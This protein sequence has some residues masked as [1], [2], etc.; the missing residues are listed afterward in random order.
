MAV[1]P[2]AAWV[3]WDLVA[4]TLVAEVVAAARREVAA[5]QAHFGLGTYKM[6]RDSWQAGKSEAQAAALADLNAAGRALEALA[7]TCC[8][9]AATVEARWTD[10]LQCAARE[11]AKL[12][13]NLDDN[14]ARCSGLVLAKLV[15]SRP[16]ATAARLGLHA[17]VATRIGLLMQDRLGEAAAAVGNLEV[18]QLFA[19]AHAVERGHPTASADQIHLHLMSGWWYFALKGLR[20]FQ[21]SLHSI[22]RAAARHLQLDG[23]RWCMRMAATL[24]DDPATM[25]TPY[26][27]ITTHLEEIAEI[28]ASSDGSSLLLREVHQ[29]LLNV[30]RAWSSAH[31][32]AAPAR[33]W[34]EQCLR[35]AITC[36]RVKCA[37]FLLNEPGVKFSEHTLQHL[38]P[39]A[40]RH[41]DA[42]LVRELFAKIAASTTTSPPANVGVSAPTVATVRPAYGD[43]ELVS[44]A[45]DGDHIQLLQF[46]LEDARFH[47][48]YRDRLCYWLFVAAQKA[49]VR[50][51]HVLFA[52]MAV[53]LGHAPLNT[54]A[55]VV[56]STDLGNFVAA[57][58]RELVACV[59]QDPRCS[60]ALIH[61]D[62]T[63]VRSAFWNA[64]LP[65]SGPRWDMTASFIA[66]CPTLLTTTASHWLYEVICRRDLKR[67]EWFLAHAGADPNHRGLP[68]QSPGWRYGWYRQFDHGELRDA[69]KITRSIQDDSWPSPLCMAIIHEGSTPFVEPLLRHGAD[70]HH[71]NDEA[72]RMA[73]SVASTDVVQRL[74]DA[75]ADVTAL[76]NQALCNAANDVNA[77]MVLVLLK[78]GA[79]VHARNE[80][81]LRAA[82]RPNPSDFV[83]RYALAT[84]ALENG[85]DV[86]VD[87]DWPVRTAAAA[88]DHEMVRVLVSHGADVTAR[89]NEALRSV[90]KAAP[91][92]VQANLLQ[93]LQDHGADAGLA[94]SLIR[95]RAER[96]AARA[97][98][99][100]SKRARGN[101]KNTKGAPKQSKGAAKGAKKTGKSG[102]AV[103]AGARQEVATGG[104]T[105]G[106]P[107]V[108]KRRR[109][110]SDLSTS[111]RRK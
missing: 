66:A 96:R 6:Q 67:T 17:S 20:D 91:G 111:K 92:E 50:A 42:D 5:A 93:F 77:P 59:L 7:R 61:A 78:N 80:F 107:A 103:D 56:S 81:T 90:C 52:E 23:F 1:M 37:Q 82:M 54:V 15:V 100:A 33:R 2:A 69:L 29:E 26:M 22:A 76:D 74:I 95:A 86:H 73:S 46:L 9:G 105:S 109:N 10:V 57:S 65:G 4:A 98:E 58:T 79:D 102:K 48:N 12:P 41:G 3:A 19:D 34:R 75:G 39:S 43:K 32:F 85:A 35:S 27:D 13:D 24:D 88:L 47:P 106:P 62:Y 97:Q 49:T 101:S 38:L 53:T 104:R 87:E 44:I 108:G 11:V 18:I 64:P 71:N 51:A 63:A 83:M 28:A 94:Q 40:C 25:R 16:T 70:V 68:E 8:D 60:Q 84:A 89:D 14:A 21:W 72:L 45:I 55:Q 36:G 30:E 99:Q 31:P 110:E